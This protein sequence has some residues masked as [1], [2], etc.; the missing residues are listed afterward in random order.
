MRASEESEARIPA[1]FSHDGRPDAG[2]K[3]LFHTLEN[4][5][6]IDTPVRARSEVETVR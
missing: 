2:R 4:K 6:E 3:R 5:V 1:R